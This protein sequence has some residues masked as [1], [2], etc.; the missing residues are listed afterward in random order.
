ML[1]SICVSRDQFRKW[2]RLPPAEKTSLFRH[3][4]TAWMRGLVLLVSYV[5]RSELGPCLSNARPE[6]LPESGA[7]QERTLEAVSSRPLLDGVSRAQ[8]DTDPR[9]HQFERG[10]G[11]FGGSF[12]E[13]VR[14]LDCAGLRRPEDVCGSEEG[15]LPGVR[16]D[17]G[18]RVGDVG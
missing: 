14:L 15:S 7:R 4:G 16:I 2:A 8:D 10:S 12:G 6:L 17:L 13:V 11:E 9:E 18:R 1:R 3:S 5:P